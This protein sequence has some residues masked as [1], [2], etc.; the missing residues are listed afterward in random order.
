MSHWELQVYT[1]EQVGTVVFLLVFSLAV[2]VQAQLSSMP[3]ESLYEGQRLSAVELIANPHRDVGPLRSLVVQKAGQPFSE[4]SV[5]AT[6]DALEK[7]GFSKVGVEMISNASGLQLH[8]ILEPPYYL[9]VIEFANLAK[10][11]SYPQLLKVV[12]LS[13]DQPYDKASLAT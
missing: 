6:I 2:P 10:Y 8:F 1:Y 13:D 4:G 3:A 11:F 9:G 12:N 7:R 5:R